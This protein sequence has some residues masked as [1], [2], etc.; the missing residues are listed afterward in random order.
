MKHH[1]HHNIE[2]NRW[3]VATSLQIIVIVLGE[4]LGGSS[5]KLL[6]VTGLGGFVDLEF[7]GL[8]GGGLDE[9]EGVVAGE[10]A[11]QPEEG[12]LEVVVGLGG[13]VVVLEVLLAVEGD[14]LGLDLAVLDLDLVA[15]EDDG[16]V[17]ADAGEVAV[18]VGDVLVG[19]AGGDVEHDDGALALD[20][21]SV[22]EAAE[23]LLSGGVPNVELDGA[24]VGVEDEGVDLDAEGGDVLLLELTGQVTLDEG[25]LADSAVSD[26]DELELG[27]FLCGGLW[28]D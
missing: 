6:L 16:D 5:G 28:L 21:V 2:S 8:E 23:L 12:L 10:L 11:G 1:L 15:G 17:L 9:V 7:G 19:D 14:L 3:A 13:D 4:G 24:A 18:P 27:H 26:E 22:A 25:G 20:V